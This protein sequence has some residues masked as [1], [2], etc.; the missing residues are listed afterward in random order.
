V[1]HPVFAVLIFVMMVMSAPPSFAATFNVSNQTQFENAL[2]TAQA[3]GQDDT[4]IMAAGLYCGFSL[5]TDENYSLTILGAGAGKTIIE[6][7][8]YNY[9]HVMTP[10]N[11]ASAHFTLKGVTLQG[12]TSSHCGLKVTVTQANVT[13]ENCE[14][15]NNSSYSEGAGLV[16]NAAGTSSITLRNNVFRNNVTD[17]MGAGAY[18]KSLGSITLEKNTFTGN[19]AM[20]SGGGLAAFADGS[21]TITLSGNIFVANIAGETADEGMG[22]GASVLAQNAPVVMVNNI[23]YDNSANQSAG[24]QIQSMHSGTITVVNNTFYK[25]TAA[26]IGGLGVA[27][28]TGTTNIYNNIFYGNISTIVPADLV[29]VN[30]QEVAI[31]INVYNN[32]AGVWLVEG[33]A[34]GVQQGGN[35]SDDPLLDGLWHLMEGSP[36]INKGLATAPS[37]PAVD[38][39]DNP[40]IVDG[41]VDIG[42]AE[43]AGGFKARIIRGGSAFGSY[44]NLHDAYSVAVDGDIIETLAVE[45][46]EA[47]VFARNVRVSMLGGYNYKY[48]QNTDMTT[49]NGSVTIKSGTLN[50]CGWRIW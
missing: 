8:Q 10:V 4:I 21:A 19:Q 30:Q 22:G 1:K 27:P 5:P 34:T 7:C 46:K 50:T 18:V 42:A 15:R 31:P 39:D 41:A 40:R 20:S 29:V 49:I 23:F 16:V 26:S 9:W 37:L 36:C 28:W 17:S 24:A 14:I 32:D 47:L 33:I 3:N 11:D 2:E 48:T 38:I 35:I 12:A 6:P 25:N 45:F 44:A 13:I 43:F